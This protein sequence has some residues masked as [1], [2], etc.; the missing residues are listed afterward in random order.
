[1]PERVYSEAGSCSEV[2]VLC[3]AVQCCAVLCN[4]EAGK[5]LWGGCC[6]YEES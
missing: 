6:V 1:M 4:G 5:G 2:Q 3:R